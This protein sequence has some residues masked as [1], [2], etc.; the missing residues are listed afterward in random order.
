MSPGKKT[1]FLKKIRSEIATVRRKLALTKNNKKPGKKLGKVAG[2]LKKKAVKEVPKEEEEK[3]K[4]KEESDKEEENHEDVG[5]LI[6]QIVDCC[7]IRIVLL[8]GVKAY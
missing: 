1:K 3:P 5:E 7:N 6:F 8:P 4:E 2:K